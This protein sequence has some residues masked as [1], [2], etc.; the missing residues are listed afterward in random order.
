MDDTEPKQERAAWGSQ[1]EF[2]LTCVG[3]AVGLGNVWRF[4]YLC[5][6]NGG[7]AFLIPYFICMVIIG[8]PMFYLELCLGQFCSLGPLKVWRINPL[9]KGLGLA[10]IIV[11]ALVAIYY[12]VI[13]AYCLYFLVASMQSEVPW[14]YCDNDWNTCDCRDGNQNDSLIDPWNGTRPEC[15]NMTYTH[16]KSASDEYFNHKVLEK[17]SG[18]DDMQGVKWTLTLCNLFVWLLTFIVLSRG[19]KSLGKVVYFSATFP[20]ILLTALLI[21]GLLLEGHK[22]GITFYLTP[23]W[24]KL[25]EASV[26]SDAAVQ[27]FYSLGTCQGGLIAMASYNQFK[28]NTLRDSLLIPVIN[29]LTSFYAGFVIFSVLG[30]MAHKKNTSVDQVV[31]EG[32][33]LAFVVYP[34]ALAQM[35]ISPLWAVLFFI[36]MMTLGF[37]SLF[38]ITETVIT[39]LVD[40]MGDFVEKSNRRLYIFRFCICALFFLLGLPMTTKGGMYMLNLLDKS[41]G[42]FPL[43][44]VGFVELLVI[45]YI[46][47]ISNRTHDTKGFPKILFRGYLR[48]KSDIEMML[49]RGI[50]VTIGFFYFAPTWCFIAPIALLV[51]I[52]LKALQWKPYTLDDYVY[53]EWATALSWLIVAFPITFIPAWILYYCACRDKRNLCHPKANWGPAFEENRTGLYSK[54]LTSFYQSPVASTVLEKDGYQFIRKDTNEVNKTNIYQP[55][56]EPPVMATFE[57]RTDSSYDN[58]SYVHDVVEST[59]L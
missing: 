51:V 39:G 14:K 22:E 30:F 27:I 56:S 3:F 40:Q 46:Y 10:M 54:D 1:L 23:D 5:F 12:A 17:T 36:M 35:P 20:Y 49:G 47:G 29:C 38:S 33:G 6:K 7:G 18:M 31:D 53:P 21:R 58:K 28:N 44:V 42:G 41:V 37:S 45:I 26:W 34:E 59:K 43:L 24:S 48:M 15:L 9:F 19:I 8:I 57:S 4:P 25:T 55:Y 11:S 50:P 13:I 2:I 52:V 32:P 16:T